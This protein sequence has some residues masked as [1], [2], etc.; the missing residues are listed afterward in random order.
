MCNNSSYKKKD[1]GSRDIRSV[2]TASDWL[3]AD[4]GKVTLKT[5][6]AAMIVNA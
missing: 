5:I 4:L 6:I 1:N 3:S 2:D